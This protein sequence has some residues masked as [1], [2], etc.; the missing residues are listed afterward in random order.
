[1]KKIYTTI[2]ASIIGTFAVMAQEEEHSLSFM[3]NGQVLANGATITVSET[4]YEDLGDCFLVEMDPHISVKNNESITVSA[5]MDCDGIGAN[6]SA[7]EFCFGNCFP[8]INN[9]HLSNTVKL[10]AGQIFAAMIHIQDFPE[11]K[12]FTITDCGVKLTLYPQTDPDDAV[13][14]TLLFD[15]T[16]AGIKDC[17]E[18]ASVE[19][20]NLCGKKIADSANGLKQGIY[21]IRKNG[22]SRKVTIK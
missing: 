2:L 19:V 16:G 12:N 17:K 11:E 4:Q 3:Q 15:T 7:I 5:T 22:V 8:W 9:T 6:Y 18:P 13:V 21:I 10:Q 1:M 20:F 14:L